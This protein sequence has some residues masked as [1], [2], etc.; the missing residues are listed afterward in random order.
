MVALIY[1]GNLFTVSEIYSV[2]N[3]EIRLTVLTDLG[4]FTNRVV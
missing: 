1:L 3:R 4:D 2:T